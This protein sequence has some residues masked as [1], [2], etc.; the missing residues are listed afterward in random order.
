VLVC[1]LPT[2][3]ERAFKFVLPVSSPAAVAFLVISLNTDW[4]SL[5]RVV[6]DPVNV[7]EAACVGQRQSAI[8]ER[9]DVVH[10]A[11]FDLQLADGVVRAADTHVQTGLVQFV[12]VCNGKTGGIVSALLMRRPDVRRPRV[13]SRPM[14]VSV[15]LAWAFKPARLVTTEN[16]IVYSSVNC[17][18]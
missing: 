12:T 2:K 11:V 10:R 16:P 18:G 8:Q 4:N 15:S 6:R 9:C 7:S 13:R 5:S 17:F 1:V 14:L 3:T